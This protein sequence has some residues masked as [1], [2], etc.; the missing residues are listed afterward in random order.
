MADVKT[1][2]REGGGPPPGYRW[3]VEIF[4]RAFDEAMGFLNE[5]QYAHLALQIQELAR[6]EDPTHSSTIDVRAIED[7]HELRDKGGVLRNLNVRVF[8]FVHD[9]SRAIV[10]L[11]AVKKEN[12]GPTQIHTKVTMR[13]RKSLYLRESRPAR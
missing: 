8:F 10:I 1:G 13:Q 3:N 4:Q 11:G 2:V 5:D 7:F 9:P 6:Q 12:D